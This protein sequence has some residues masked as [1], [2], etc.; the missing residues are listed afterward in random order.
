MRFKTQV[1]NIGTFTSI[2]TAFPYPKLLADNRLEFTSSLTAI[3]K[4]A[5]LRLTEDDVRFVIQAPEQGTHLWAYDC[6]V[7]LLMPL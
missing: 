2:Y 4:I 3:G 6:P 1:R 7:L 5:W